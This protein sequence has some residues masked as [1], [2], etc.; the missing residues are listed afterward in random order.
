MMPDDQEALFGR[1]FKKMFSLK[2]LHLPLVAEVVSP[3]C[4]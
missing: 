2:K 4:N 1:P 3:L